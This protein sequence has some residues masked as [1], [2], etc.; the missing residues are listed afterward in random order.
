MRFATSIIALAASSLVSAAPFRR[1]ATAQDLLVL[2]ECFLF[3]CA[4]EPNLTLTQRSPMSLSS[5]RHNSTPKHCPSSSSPTSPLLASPTRRSPL[6]SLLRF[7]QTRAP[8]RLSLRY[9]PKPQALAPL[10]SISRPVDNHLTR[11]P[12][13]YVL[14]I[15]L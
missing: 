13:P 7:R 14:P 1:A 6:N 3:Y 10:Y 5:S 12:A 4:Y 2:S 11:R 15:Q 8:T 9:V